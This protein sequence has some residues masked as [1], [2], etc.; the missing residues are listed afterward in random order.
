MVL[1]FI[2]LLT[3]LIVSFVS[4]MS[5]NRLSTTSYSKSIQ[6]Q[7]IAQGGLQDILS[8]LHSEIIAGST[9]QNGGN[10]S[11]APVYLPTTNFTA[12]PARLGYPATDWTNAATA[13]TTL[14]P[15]T[16]VRVSRADPAGGTA[17]VPSTAF[18]NTTYYKPGTLPQNRASNANT[19]TNSI[20]GRSISAAR[21]NKTFL[22]APT[23]STSAGAGFQIPS[24]FANNTPDWVYVTRAGSQVFTSVANMLPAPLSSTQLTPGAASP[25]VGRYAYVVYDE[26]AL[27]DVNVAGANH[28]AIGETA[29][30][31]LPTFTV[32]PQPTY[33]DLTTGIITTVQGKSYLAFADLTQIPGLSGAAGQTLIDNLVNW[34]NAGGLANAGGTTGPNFLQAAFTA[35]QSGFLN[36]QSN[37]AGTVS[38]RPLMSRQDLINYF[39]NSTVDPNFNTSSAVASKALPYLSTFSRAVSAPTWSPT[40]NAPGGGAYNYATNAKQP[41][42]NSPFSSTSPNPNP[43]M[44]NVRF[45]QAFPTVTHY[46][47]NATPATYAVNAGDPLM[48]S[49][50]SLAKIAWLSQ[51]NP[52]T[53]AAPGGNYPA[54]IQACFGLVWGSPGSTSTNSNH[55]ITTANGGNPCWN[56]YVGSNGNFSG[57]IETLDQVALEGR[58]PNFFELLKAA[59][60]SGSLGLDPGPAAY[61]NGQDSSTSFTNGGTSMFDYLGPSGMYCHTF[62]SSTTARAPAAVS[63]VQVMRIGANIIDQFGSDSYPTAIYFRYLNQGGELAFDPV[64]GS[65]ANPGLYGPV[66]MI[67]GDK[68]LPDLERMVPSWCSTAGNG[69]TGNTGGPTGTAGWTDY[70][71]VTAMACFYQAQLWNMHQQPASTLTNVPHNF[72][73]RAYGA[74]KSFWSYQGTG[75]LYKTGHVTQ[76]SS[77]L[78]LFYQGTGGSAEVCN[79]GTLNFTDANSGGA[80]SFYASP[81][82]L[83]ADQITGVTASSPGANSNNMASSF[84]T[85]G[86]YPPYYNKNHFVAFCTGVSSDFYTDYESPSG[87]GVNGDTDIEPSS[88]AGPV[89]FVLG[90]LDGPTIGTGNFHPYSFVT[91]AFTFIYMVIGS[92]GGLN[93]Y[94]GSCLPDDVTPYPWYVADPRTSRFATSSNYYGGYAKSPTGNYQGTTLFASS[95]NRILVNCCMPN[96]PG[97]TEVP[98]LSPANSNGYPSDWA[99]NSATRSAAAGQTAT[100][101]SYY[102]YYSD[103]DGVVR[104]GDGVF[105][106]ASSG[107]GMMLFESAG[108]RNFTGAGQGDT[109]IP[110]TVPGS[111][112]DTTGNVY[113]GRRPVILNRP[114]R[115]V[116]EL[117]YTFRDEPF[118]SLDF[119]STASADAALLDVFSITDEAKV[120]NNGLNSVV[121]GQVDLNNAPL[122]VIGSLLSVGSKKD[123]D[124]NDYMNNPSATEGA[125]SDVTWLAPAIAAN[126]NPATGTGPLLNRAGLVTQLGATPATGNGV[127]R[128][129]NLGAN[130][131]FPR[132]WD[133]DNKAYLEAPVRAL[134]DVTNTR[135]WNLMIDIIAQSGHMSQTAA[136]LNDFVVEGEK[137]YWLHIAI[138]RYTGKIVDQQLEPVYE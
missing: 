93:D 131:G 95:G 16:L 60:L 37:P 2:V 134:S 82:L 56:Y 125:A 120:A 118:K 47:D 40:S 123:F 3:I 27:L 22:L 128:N 20:D 137:R 106:K 55:T 126:L 84:V 50:F 15:P 107:D 136:T 97:F 41:S 98:P 36:F 7:E 48:Q 88:P 122:P 86:T 24:D 104:P 65:V 12:E 67:Y 124:P 77:P 51:A 68:N 81:Y 43:A 58:E 1:A 18:N 53:G 29:V 138:D 72:Q 75:L 89:T 83:S 6:A 4:F 44:A 105:G 9:V 63:D 79:N 80:S 69:T 133:Q 116:G 14:L 135:T 87:P 57:T 114:F 121:A 45:P 102:A 115:N 96:G 76:D 38:D 129:G 19:S 103:P 35:A 74:A 66:D 25:V 52:A 10:A 78:T 49:R 110:T 100:A 127:I 17:F 109:N 23:T 54:A 28:L 130:L 13:S 59:I 132:Y 64:V 5:L 108:T 8:D 94:A 90:W 46:Y 91:G 42:T 61:L 39:A 11:Y 32:T 117:G 113:N 33:T 31:T 30:G 70:A 99:V 73:I 119:F 85:G 92:G 111:G 112:G 101:Y 71:N 34:R 21:W 62:G 26:G